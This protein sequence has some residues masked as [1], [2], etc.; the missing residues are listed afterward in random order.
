M[1]TSTKRLTAAAALLA[2]TLCASPT[3]ARKAAGPARQTA[4]TSLRLNVDAPASVEV[5]T[6]D[7]KVVG[8]TA[9]KRDGSRLALKAQ[10][11]PT[12][13]TSCPAG[14]TLSCWEDEAQMMSICVC[15]GGGGGGGGGFAGQIE[16][17][18]FSW[19]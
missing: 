13:A 15:G 9:V 19:S 4:R 5:E 6:R 7:G 14:Q 8:M 3:D 2:A 1:K 12:C 17:A 10:S 18:S 11:K 16:I